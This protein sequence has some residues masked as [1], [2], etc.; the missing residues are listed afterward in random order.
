MLAAEMVNFIN[1]TAVDEMLQ[2]WKNIDVF[3][4]DYHIEGAEEICSRM[5]HEFKAA[6]EELMRRWTRIEN[7]LTEIDEQEEQRIEDQKKNQSNTTRLPSS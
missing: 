1:K 6:Q 4:S 5:L 3:F 2:K 7:L